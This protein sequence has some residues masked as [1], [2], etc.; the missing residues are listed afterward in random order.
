LK[1][2][3]GRKDHQAT[4]EHEVLTEHQELKKIGHVF[5]PVVDLK[6]RIRQLLDNYQDTAGSVTS[7]ALKQVQ[8]RLKTTGFERIS[9]SKTGS[10]RLKQQLAFE[11]RQ[12]DNPLVFHDS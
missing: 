3:Q 6:K 12:T 4:Q 8:M 10:C 7:E 2:K 1:G 11:N 5:L 9:S